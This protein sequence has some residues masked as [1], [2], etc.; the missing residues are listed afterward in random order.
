MNSRPYGSRRPSGWAHR[1]AGFFVLSALIALP[2]FAAPAAANSSPGSLAT[3]RRLASEAKAAEG[4]DEISEAADQYA[5]V[6]LA[7]GIN[8]SAEAFTAA[9]TAAAALPLSSGTA[10][11]EL[12]NQPY[13][14]DDPN[15]RD[16]IISNSGGGAGNSAGRMTALAVDP[17]RS[18]VVYAGAAAGGVWKS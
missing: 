3:K 11:S 6:R 7:P 9:R 16:P 14:S 4:A 10:W 2:L 18:S 8:V 15:F 1:L 5:A 17:A 13:N 12:T